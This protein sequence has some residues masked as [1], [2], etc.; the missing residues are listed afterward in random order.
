MASQPPPPHSGTT[1]SRALFPLWLARLFEQPHAL[2]TP[3]ANF[4]AECGALGLVVLPS[5]GLLL[6]GDAA[7]AGARTAAASLADAVAAAAEPARGAAECDLSGVATTGGGGRGLVKLHPPLPPKP[8][9]KLPSLPLRTT[10]PAA[11]APAE[12]VKVAAGAGKFD[13]SSG[14]ATPRVS[15]PITK[16]GGAKSMVPT[17]AEAAAAAVPSASV[18]QPPTSTAASRCCLLSPARVVWPPRGTETSALDQLPPVLARSLSVFASVLSLIGEEKGVE[19]AAVTAEE[20]DCGIRAGGDSERTVGYADTVSCPGGG[21]RSIY[22]RAVDDNGDVRLAGDSQRV[23]AAHSYDSSSSGSYSVHSEDGGRGNGTLTSIETVNGSPAASSSCNAGRAHGGGVSTKNIHHSDSSSSASGLT[24]PNQPD[25]N[26]SWP[27]FYPTSSS[28]SSRLVFVRV[29]WAGAWRCVPVGDGLPYVHCT[30]QQKSSTGP[31]ECS[32]SG[33]D[34]L[35]AYADA[36]PWS[37]AGPTSTGAGTRDGVM[38]PLFPVLDEQF[39]Y[40]RSSTNLHHSSLSSSS[41]YADVATASASSTTVQYATPTTSESRAGQWPALLWRAW[42]S[43]TI[44]TSWAG[45]GSIGS[46]VRDEFR[47]GGG[48]T[49]A[50][51]DPVL[52]FHSLTGALPLSLQGPPRSMGGGGGGAGVIEASDRAGHTPTSTS[53]ITTTTRGA[54]EKRYS[55]SGEIGN[56]QVDPT[57]IVAHNVAAQG[58]TVSSSSSN[59]TSSSASSTAP[60]LASTPTSIPPPYSWTPPRTLALLASLLPTT[61]GPTPAEATREWAYASEVAARRWARGIEHEERVAEAEATLRAARM[62]ELQKRDDNTSSSISSVGAEKVGDGAESSIGIAASIADKGDAILLPVNSV[63]TGSICRSTSSIRMRPLL[64]MPLLPLPSCGTGSGSAS[65]GGATI[66]VRILAV[67]GGGGA[68]RPGSGSGSSD[69]NT[70]AGKPQRST[71]SVSALPACAPY[72]SKYIAVQQ[73]T[74]LSVIPLVVGNEGEVS[75]T[76]AHL[77]EQQPHQH[78]QHQKTRPRQQRQHRQYTRHL[79][80]G[81]AYE[82]VE[83]RSSPLVL[84]YTHAEGGE[85]GASALAAPSRVRRAEEDKRLQRL[86]RERL[87]RTTKPRGVAF[88]GDSLPGSGAAT[89]AIVEEDGGDS[90]DNGEGS[91]LVTAGAVNGAQGGDGVITDAGSAPSTSTSSSNSGATRATNTGNGTVTTLNSGGLASASAGG[92]KLR[93]LPNTSRYSALAAQLLVGHGANISSTSGSGA[94]TAA[95]LACAISSSSVHTGSGRKAGHSIGPAS[96]TSTAASAVAAEGSGGV[97]GAIRCTISPPSAAPAADRQQRHLLCSK[98]DP[99]IRL[100][101]PVVRVPVTHTTEVD[102]EGGSYWVVDC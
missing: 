82:I 102:N 37:G 33:D 57:L 67:C 5:S 2:R 91:M 25:I 95:T 72:V 78:H 38:V 46:I 35:D 7:A 51:C 85:L 49:L 15:T 26:A 63:A 99:L 98:N 97:M 20:T 93:P 59:S 14:A 58:V 60:D 48:G 54:A 53:T 92:A 44:S 9:A 41:E 90:D 61:P 68:S 69:H 21:W 43:L 22:P 80:E 101:G 11:S 29:F 34:A 70:G 1:Q 24:T 55:L 56:Q 28:V 64:V 18:G 75:S 77:S 84:S 87:L 52:M 86:E 36:L 40:S 39:G 16:P 19:A 65:V 73:A 32:T 10:T 81:A 4:S 62:R 3:D 31:H 8:A 30:S 23:A 94:S 89:R 47:G 79:V 27:P 42:W 66:G 17:T 83:L 74:Q 100:V 76:V 13:S 12:S 96:S 71:H 88:S 45:V 50:C 6:A